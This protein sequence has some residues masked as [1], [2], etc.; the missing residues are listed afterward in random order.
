ME[1]VGYNNLCYDYPL[2]HAIM[3]APANLLT[4]EYI[5]TISNGI[6]NNNGMGGFAPAIWGNR[7]IVPQ[8]DLYLLHHFN[9]KARRTSLKAIEFWQ[10]SDNID[11]LEFSFVDA[12]PLKHFDRVHE[13]NLSD[14]IETEKFLEYSM[15]VLQLRQD[16]MHGNRQDM[17]WHNNGKIGKNIFI[18]LIGHSNCFTK[19]NGEWVA[20]GTPRSSVDLGEIMSP[21]IEC[22]TIPQFKAIK[23]FFSEQVVVG[24]KGVL[25]PKNLDLPDYLKKYMKRVTTPTMDNRNKAVE[26]FESDSMSDEEKKL[27]YPPRMNAFLKRYAKDALLPSDRL[28]GDIVKTNIVH[29]GLEYVFGTGG[30]HASREK[31]FYVADEKYGIYDWDFTAYYPSLARLLGS[32][33]AQFKIEDWV[34]VNLEIWNRRQAF[35]KGTAGYAAYKEA[36]NIP[37]GLSGFPESP[38]YDPK[39]MLSTCINGQLLL[40]TLIERLILK[41]GATIIQANTDGVTFKI[42]RTLV[43]KANEVAREFEKHTKNILLVESVEYESM[44]IRNVNNYI[45]T[46]VSGDVKMK[47]FY[48]VDK[49]PH[50]DTSQLIVQK[51]IL[52]NLQEGTDVED[53]IY[54]HDDPWD[55]F[56]R[57]KGKVDG[58]S[59]KVLRYY[60]STNGEVLTKINPKVNT[61]VEGES[62]C[63]PMQSVPKGIRVLPNLNYQYYVDQVY[64]YLQFEEENI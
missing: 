24:T 18:D 2:L 37:Y 39:Y 61:T 33:P 20:K 6:I 11:E 15:P 19:V 5:H 23:Q 35:T 7:Q 52:A 25:N 58:Y 41:T 44:H 43:D 9:N 60:C 22:E 27:A 50:K 28:I 17:R 36:G 30:L 32:C 12:L 55:F 38:F 62:L 53:F 47:G 16:L 56:K 46:Y 31:A 42:E 21:L 48:E 63:T 59:G 40:M 57:V 10:R 8:W 26:I 13:Y 34:R 3:Y 64:K 45:A 14:V 1:M 4:A 29:D 49:L 54:G 51:A